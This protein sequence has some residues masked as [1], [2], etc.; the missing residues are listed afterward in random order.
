MDWKGR[1]SSDPGVCNGRACISGTRIPVSVVLDNLADGLTS[2][3]IAVA[4]VA[5]MIA[6][7][8]GASPEGSV[9]LSDLA[10]EKILGD[11]TD[12][13]SADPD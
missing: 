5:E 10:R 13:T 7:R 4:I 12:T 8:R 9:A 6:V 11:G 1:I 2:E 3:E